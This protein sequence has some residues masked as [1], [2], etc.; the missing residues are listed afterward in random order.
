MVDVTATNPDG[1]YPAG[2]TIHIR[3]VLS[4]PVTVTGTPQLRYSWTG[5]IDGF[6]SYAGGS[7]GTTTLAFDYAVQPGDATSDLSQY[8]PASLLPHGGSIADGAGNPATLVLPAA[9]MGDALA[10]NKAILLD[11]MPPKLIGLVLATGATTHSFN[12]PGWNGGSAGC[13]AAICGTAADSGSGT[14]KV[15]V[16]DPGIRNERVL[17]REHVQPDRRDL[18][19]SVGHDHVDTATARDS[20]LERTDLYGSFQG[21]R[22]RRK[23]DDPPV[24]RLPLRHRCSERLIRVP[25]GRRI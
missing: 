8:D 1:G 23:R 4:E 13:A 9:G 25:T 15:E 14:Q 7:S 18:P 21:L 6:A 2:S 22:P 19:H 20:T 24:L 16:S 17:R 11:T 10:D 5:Q 3:I 12:A